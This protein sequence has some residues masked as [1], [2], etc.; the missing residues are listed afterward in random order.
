MIIRRNIYNVEGRFLGL[1]QLI[2]DKGDYLWK[3]IIKSQSQ[4]VDNTYPSIKKECYN[5][6]FIPFHEDD[7]N[8]DL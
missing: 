1:Y 3:Y 7:L 4:Q 8:G 6:V 2:S 5:A